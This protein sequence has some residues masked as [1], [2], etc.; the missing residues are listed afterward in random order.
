MKKKREIIF[1]NKLKKIKLKIYV[2]LFLHPHAYKIDSIRELSKIL[3]LVILLLFKKF[4]DF[5]YF[6]SPWLGRFYLKFS[7]ENFFNF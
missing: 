1:Y 7:Q 4:P 6:F 3:F 5:K 2:I